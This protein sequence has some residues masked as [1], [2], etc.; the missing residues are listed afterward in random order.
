MND[1]FIGTIYG[2]DDASYNY[3]SCYCA[4]STRMTQGRLGADYRPGGGRYLTKTDNS[5]TSIQL[6]SNQRY[7]C[8]IYFFP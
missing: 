8:F 5:D 6:S 4:L 7:A 1:Q 3:T 2:L